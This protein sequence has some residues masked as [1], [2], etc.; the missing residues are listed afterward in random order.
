MMTQTLTP[1]L[2]SVCRSVDALTRLL[3]LLVVAAFVP[4]ARGNTPSGKRKFELPAGDATAT[5]KSFAAQ[6]GEQV[7]YVVPKVRG[8][9]TQAVHGE[10][11]AREALDRML[12]DTVLVVVVDAAT[13]ALLVH[14]ANAPA[15]EREATPAAPVR[16]EAPRTQRRAGPIAALAAWLG[17]TL[18]P[19]S[20]VGAAETTGIGGIEGRVMNAG[21]GEYLENARLTIQGTAL[22]TFSRPDGFY[23]FGV[24]PA[25]AVTVSVF[26][27]GLPTAT[28][29]VQVGPG[30]TARRDFELGGKR[31]ADGAVVQLDK[32][33]VSS[34]KQMDGAA[35]A[36]HEQRFAPNIL[37]VVSADEFG[38]VAEGNVGDF[39]KFLPGVTIDYG[40]GDARTISLSGVPSNNVPVTIGGFALASAASSGTSRT[41]ELEQ[42]SINNLARVEIVHS[43]TPESPGSALAGSVNMVPRSAF[44]RSK[45]SF[46]TNVFLMM[47]DNAKDL[48]K[49]PGPR[50]EPTRKIQP[51]FDFTYIVPM[52]RRWGFTLSG[53]NSTQYTSEDFTQSTWRGTSAATTG[54][55]ATTNNNQYPDTAP[56]A[57]YLTDFLIQDSA[58]FSRR[59]SLGATVDFRLSEHDRVSFSFQYAYFDAD[60]SNRMLTFFVNRIAPGDFGPTFT[61]GEVG[62]GVLRLDN[63]GMRRKSGTTYMPTL[64]YRHDGRLWRAEAGLGLSRAS[65]HY[66]DSEHGYF[67]NSQGRRAGVTIDFDEI[68]Y[69]RPGRITV[70]EGT[71]G[72][73]ID[74]YRIDNFVI[75]NA[76][77]NPRDSSDLQRSAF[78]N[79][80]RDFYLRGAPLALK[81]GFD[82]R[83]SVRDI[84]GASPTWNFV[85]ADGRGST[86]PIDGS[87][88]GARAVFDANFSQRRAP[89]GFGAI[90][91][92]SGEKLWQLYE[93]NPSYFTLDQ[94][95]AYRSAVGFSKRAAEVISAVYARG[96]LSLID[97]RLKLVG[98]VRA[99]QT[100][101]TAEGPL[102][103]PTRNF[104]RDSAGRAILGPNGR[105]L[106][107]ATDSLGVSRLTYIDRGLTAQ[108]EY[109]RLFPSLNASFNLREN[110]VARGSV[111][112]SVGRPDFNQYA[113]GIT[114]PDTESPPSAGN[115]I[116]VNNAGIKAWSARSMKVRLEYYF[117]RV[118][119]VSVGAYRRD[120]ENF[121]G[122]TI[123]TP[124]PEFLSL[125]DLD[126]DLYG[127]YDA[128]TQFNIASTVRMQG[129]E[130]DYKQAL[131][132]LPHW[133]RGVQVFANASAQ[134]ATG[135]A[136]S[137]FSGYIPRTYNWGV[138]LSR[139]R[140]SLKMNWNYRGKQRRGLQTGRGIEP[141][142]Y[143]WGSKRLYID[144]TG[145][146]RLFRSITAFGSIRNLRS[147]TEDFKVYGPSTPDWG[148]FRQRQDYGA[149]WVFGLRGVY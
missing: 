13:G 139:E 98:G 60:L 18:A 28:D 137:N 145:E 64:T 141:E 12:R 99:E 44:E 132:F 73:V 148:K 109:L 144:L 74:P 80:R 88:D 86:T 85:G 79:L 142:T 43:P 25:G 69:L 38:F 113:G 31:G 120:F 56:N 134:R 66:R 75:L 26:Y 15:A 82:V 3:I 53:G 4:G 140:Y 68:F 8:V 14:R 110:L 63:N 124:S 128:S 1:Y 118:G 33:V 146:V 114:L 136:A 106:P 59:S 19:V 102:N 5:L 24:V 67:A 51:G 147:A 6:S 96:D 122:S 46:T 103:D 42:V 71:T 130:F 127:R 7:I 34:A 107:I 100:N 116:T 40:G 115:R 101:I 41:V 30:Q 90:D 36:I 92:V 149:S 52:S 11:A 72:Q 62:R 55:T 23:R 22:E 89:F 104:Q 65:N 17:L 119:Q 47:K 91:W 126:P 76:S 93:R 35:I 143:N 2:L 27:T 138:S 32:F 78:G 70:R 16:E 39:L 125:Y 77:T 97:R 61:H 37:N 95:G 105:P 58:K 48:Q 57:P 54:L 21:N 50:A 117:E 111:Y 29:T 108:K 49:T 123:F 45:P 135:P 121:F 84:R 131:T 129:L 20:L 94:N 81:A 112:T 133:A 87:D 10:F 83:E 9:R